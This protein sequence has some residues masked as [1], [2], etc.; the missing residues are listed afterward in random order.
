VANACRRG[1]RTEKVEK[2]A[3]S[4]YL[5]RKSKGKENYFKKQRG[6]LCGGG[7]EARGAARS[8]SKLGLVE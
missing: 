5:H 7:I 6:K 8:E 3:E 2:S 4:I 1:A